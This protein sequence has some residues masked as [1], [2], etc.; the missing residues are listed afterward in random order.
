MEWESPEH[1][2]QGLGK[3]LMNYEL[4]QIHNKGV[5]AHLD[6]GPY[7]MLLQPMME[8]GTWREILLHS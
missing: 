2:H 6:R 4:R 8:E 1:A 7:Y 5:L 3:V